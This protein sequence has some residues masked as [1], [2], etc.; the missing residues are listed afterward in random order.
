MESLY[1][2]KILFKFVQQADILHKKNINDDDH[3]IKF[4]YIG[5][6]WRIVVD[7]LLSKPEV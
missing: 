5:I 4:Y 6:H 3:I 1:A 7:Q 2:I